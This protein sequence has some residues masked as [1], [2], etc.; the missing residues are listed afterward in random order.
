MN[1]KLR[2]LGAM[3]ITM[4]LLGPAVGS[5]EWIAC[6]PAPENADADAENDVISVVILQDGA[7]I[8]RPYELT[9]DGEHVKLVDVSVIAQAD[10]QFQFENKHGRRSD[11]VDYVLQPKPNGCTGIK[12]IQTE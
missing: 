6:N 11:P 3:L 2:V 8:I 1:Y 5:A 9:A 12:I 10:Y 7:E 4:F